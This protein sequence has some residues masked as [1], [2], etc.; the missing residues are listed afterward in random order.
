MCGIVAFSAKSE[1]ELEL[2][3]LIESMINLMHHRGPDF[4]NLSVD[5]EA[6]VGMAHARLSIL[7]LSDKA[8]QP[9]FSENNSLSIVFNGEIYNWQEL[10]K[11]LEMEG[12]GPFVTQSDTEVILRG[13][14]HY[15]NDLPL[16][17][18]GMFAFVIFDKQSNSLFCAR[19]RVGKKPLVYTETEDGVA[20]ASEIPPLLLASP[21]SPLNKSALATILLHNMRHVPDPDTAFSAISRLRAGH[22]MTVRD[23]RIEKIWRYWQPAIK[24]PAVSTQDLRSAIEGAVKRRM[25]AD[26]PV[27]ALL[28]GGVD[29]TAVVALMA[30][31]TEQPVRTYA[32]GMDADDEDLRRARFVA[33]QLGCEHKEFYFD[34]E[35][36]FEIFRNIQ[37]TY[38]EP[39]A[40]LPLVHSYELC[41]A[42]RDDGIKVV[43][44]GHGADELFYGYTG[45][46]KT[47]L[48][49][50]A[51]RY[52]GFLRPAAQMIPRAL[53][54]GPSV[55]LAEQPGRRKAAL[56]RSYQGRDWNQVIQPEARKA[57]SN[58][59]ARECEYWGSMLGKADYIDESNFIALMMENSHSVTTAAD[60]PAMM[61]S[62]EMRAP[63]L[64][65][66][67]VEMAL[68]IPYRR[69]VPNSRDLSRLKYALKIAVE[70]LV[71]KHLLYAPKRG[72]GHG[73]QEKDILLGPWREIANEVFANSIDAEGLFDVQAIRKLWNRQSSGDESVSWG[74]IAKLFTIQLWLQEQ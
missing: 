48:L 74:F 67:I 38:G 44:T 71:P 54:S 31:H 65:Q 58:G 35:R 55:L 8:N 34:A 52:L 45:H 15:G 39:I 64:D 14:E 33:S 28:S 32:L 51:L 36:Q 73:I 9:M 47:A 4:H 1:S 19:D 30:R 26:V 24:S 6:K 5:S 60:L 37:K 59:A 69:K 23:G 41:S 68:S 27:G 46:A 21:N 43:L 13:Y 18:R 17:L 7:D 70:D 61:A 63:F 57:L 42:I 62:V 2:G 66:E 11:K 3:P 22:A 53:R 40:L 20:L 12:V 50:D 25:V 49:T 16:H 10:R 56:Y 72:F 29:S